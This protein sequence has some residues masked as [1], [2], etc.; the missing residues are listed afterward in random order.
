M[1]VLRAVTGA[2]TLVQGCC[3]GHERLPR[4]APAAP[5]V[6]W[7][8]RVRDLP[9]SFTGTG[10][11]SDLHALEYLQNPRARSRDKQVRQR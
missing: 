2:G 10:R 5:G 11:I 3:D 8:E 9:V 1:A 4:L 7:R 6:C